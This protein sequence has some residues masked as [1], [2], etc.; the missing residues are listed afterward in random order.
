MDYRY[1]TKN[2]ARDFHKQRKAF[3]ILNG[4]LEFMPEGSGMSHYE[5]CNKKG[6]SKEEFN[7]ITRGYY[8]NG[9]VIF[10]KDNFIYDDEVISNAL[11]VIDEI[12][13]KINVN[14]FNIYFGQLPDQDFKL[15][16]HYGKYLNGKIIK[17]D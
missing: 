7:K 4:K 5:Y 11:K 6:L 17:I 12:S 16:F 14:E 13:K 10:Y 15:D 9:N 8:L 2:E 3:I 1:E